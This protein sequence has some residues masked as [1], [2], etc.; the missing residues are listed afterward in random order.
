MSKKPRLMNIA[1]VA[2]TV[3]M[4]F[5]A[6]VSCNIAQNT[7]DVQS[8]IGQIAKLTAETKREADAMGRQFPQIKREAD[9]A[10]NGTKALSDQLREM[11]KQTALISANNDV[12]NQS[13]V[14]SERPV[15]YFG[16]AEWSGV[17]SQD[18]KLNWQLLVP[19]G[20][21]GKSPTIGLH[22]FYQCHPSVTHLAKPWDEGALM[23]QNNGLVTL[24]PGVALTPIACTIDD[25]H[26]KQAPELM[27][28]LY[29]FGRA[30]YRAAIAP[31][32]EHVSEFCYVITSI[33]VKNSQINALSLACESHNCTDQ[34]CS[35]QQ[36][37]LPDAGK[38]AR[39]PL[40][41]AEPGRTPTRD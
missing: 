26:L 3:V 30:K 17:T 9:S 29:V 39:R 21:S 8:A 18:G 24:G 34:E 14:V 25:E 31:R 32:Q 2:A 41:S 33:S 36:R 7:Q 4:A 23:P 27:P 6:V 28:Y 22:Y 37:K 5:A 19:L 20:N 16:N 13:F 11:K 35:Q 1:N 38:S 40:R 12:A 10:E 15:V